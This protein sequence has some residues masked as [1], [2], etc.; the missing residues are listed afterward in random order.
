LQ[1][2]HLVSFNIPYP[3]DNGGLIDVFCKVK[4]LHKAGAAIHLH[5]YAY[6]R[7]QA[8]ELEKYCTSVRYYPR[9]GFLSSLFTSKPYI[10]S[11][12][13]S[14][15]LRE[16]LRKD[17]LPV[18][19][20]GLHTTALLEY[21]EFGNRRIY[22]RT[23]NIEH[24]YYGRLADVESN[25]LKK[26]YFKEE[27]RRLK[28]YEPIL[29]RSAG[30]FAI[31]AADTDWFSRYN[32]NCHRISAF[33]LLDSPDIP[34]GTGKGVVYHGSLDVAEN[35]HAALWIAK[36]IAPG[37]PYS[38][39]IAGKNPGAELERAAAKSGNIRIISDTDTKG[40][41]QL[42]SEAHI[43]L[44]PTFQSTGIKLKLL[45]ALFSGRH[46]LVNSPMVDKT[47]LESV[48]HKAD[49]A[50][51]M[52]AAIEKL[53]RIE[54]TDEEIRNREALLNGDFSNDVNA[55]RMLEILRSTQS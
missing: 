8:P 6:G 18:V 17:D 22:V 26:L 35:R 51:E 32:K 40:I 3:A 54:M 42:V 28:A 21:P 15:T 10:V 41:Q 27:S 49:T 30:I 23:H 37:L 44:L 52:R 50:A 43:N 38:F 4:S 24:E 19:L 53:M 7:A 48:C 1:E 29:Q 20:E 13:N 46:C 9:S 14:E 12:R 5:C 33:H 36:E 2:F 55:K 25:P 39:I 45:L 11:S 47:G 16:V 34:K 31:S